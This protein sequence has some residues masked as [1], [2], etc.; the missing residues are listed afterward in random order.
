MNAFDA[1]L[2]AFEVAAH[3]V[4]EIGEHAWIEREDKIVK[5]EMP[6]INILP[7]A[8]NFTDLG[9]DTTAARFGVRVQVFIAGPRPSA[10]AYPLAAALHQQL[11]SSPELPQLV[12]NLPPPAIEEPQYN[13]DDGM[14]CCLILR[15]QALPVLDRATLEFSS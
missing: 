15:Y 7:G 14:L 10:R 6:A 9:D 12:A 3:A 2:S 1:I 4:P 8:T 11:L 5:A 13:G